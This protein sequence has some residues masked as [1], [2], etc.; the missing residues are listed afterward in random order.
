MVPATLPLVEYLKLPSRIETRFYLPEVEGR[1][2]GV[3]P[4]LEPQ[5]DIRV[6]PIHSS[7]SS[8]L[9]RRVA[10]FEVETIA[11]SSAK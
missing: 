5:H 1:V 8:S 3:E 9:L 10:I 2:G 11:S 4:R 6:Q 7:L